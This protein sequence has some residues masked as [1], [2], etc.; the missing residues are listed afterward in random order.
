MLRNLGMAHNALGNYRQARDFH[1]RA[2]DLHG[3]RQG[4]GSGVQTEGLREG[5]SRGPKAEA[6]M[7]L[8]D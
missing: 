4:L 3:E 1:Q 5:V 2:A 6:W 7:D 8:E